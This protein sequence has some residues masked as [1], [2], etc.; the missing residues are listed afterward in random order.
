MSHAFSGFR[1]SLNQ[2]RDRNYKA[3]TPTCI[4]LE[5]SKDKQ[6]SVEQT[7][8]S[9]LVTKVTLVIILLETNN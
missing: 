8:Q 5:K 2:L 9:R 4:Q 7:F 6:L 1:D 3:K